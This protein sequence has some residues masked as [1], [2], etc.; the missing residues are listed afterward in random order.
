MRA[1]ILDCFLTNFESLSTSD[2]VEFNN[3]IG[4]AVRRLRNCEASPIC[5]LASTPIGA[6]TL[7]LSINFFMKLSR[8]FGV[9]KSALVFILLIFTRRGSSRKRSNTRR[10][11]GSSSVDSRLSSPSFFCFMI[12]TSSSSSKLSRI[13]ATKTLMIIRDEKR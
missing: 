1:V 6:S 2:I 3:F 9:E 5:C 11:N 10:R 13:T 7:E 12:F 4:I 8:I